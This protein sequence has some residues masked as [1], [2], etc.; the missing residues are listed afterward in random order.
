MM[1]GLMIETPEDPIPFL[2]EQL[3]PENKQPWWVIIMGPPKSHRKEHTLVL[4][5]H[6]K[7]ECLSVG[8]LL[9]KEV[10]KKSEIG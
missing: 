5:E 4:A 6:F 3:S 10:N 7:Y 8:D 9:E 1:N 2:I